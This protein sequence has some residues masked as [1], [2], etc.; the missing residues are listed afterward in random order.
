MND[1]E[2]L[3]QVLKCPVLNCPGNP[4]NVPAI[5]GQAFLCARQRGLCCTCDIV[6]ALASSLGEAALC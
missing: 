2:D 3:Q 1:E 4:S 6:F 5:S